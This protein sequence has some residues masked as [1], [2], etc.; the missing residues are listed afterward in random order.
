MKRYFKH[1][2]ENLI[3]ITKIVTVNHLEFE[4]DFIFGGESHDFWE[5]VYADKKN[6][7]ITA[8]AQE[9]ELQAGQMYLHK[10]NEFHNLEGN[11]KDFPNVSIITFECN[12]PAMS[13][14]EGKIFKLNQEEKNLLSQVFAEGLSCYEMEDHENPLIQKMHHKQNAPF[15]CSQST[16]NLL[17]LFLISS[18]FP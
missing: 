1:K 5:I 14:F 18:Y 16:K 15:G 3:N 13:Y 2:P 7:F 10:P 12:S 17:E 11:N 6:L 4:K 8:G 9:I